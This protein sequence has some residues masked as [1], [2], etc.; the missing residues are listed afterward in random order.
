MSAMSKTRASSKP[1]QMKKIA[2]LTI[3]IV[4]GALLPPLTREAPFILVLAS[5]ALLAGVLALSLDILTGSVGFARFYWKH[6]KRGRDES[7][8][9][10]MRQRLP[11]TWRRTRTQRSS[12]VSFGTHGKVPCWQQSLRSHVRRSTSS[13]TR[14]RDNSRLPPPRETDTAARCRRSSRLSRADHLCSRQPGE[15]RQ[16]C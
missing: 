11:E 9:V 4:V 5:H 13:V 12:P 7:A 2:L 3:L 14:F 16:P 15:V 8:P 10:W 6:F 1:P